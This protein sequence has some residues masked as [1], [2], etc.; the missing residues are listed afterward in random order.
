MADIRELKD[1]AAKQFSKGKF[2]KAARAYEQLCALEPRDVQM[3][4]RLGDALVKN[5]E[6]ETAVKAYQ[7][8]AESYAREGFLPRAI[9]VC[10]L[11]LE[12]DP[13]HESTQEIL[14]NLYARR[15]GRG[16]AGPQAPSGSAP[17]VQAKSP[18]PPALPKHAQSSVAI[19]LDIG[20]LGQPEL[21]EGAAP[22]AK[23]PEPPEGNLLSGARATDDP[24]SLAALQIARIEEDQE[25]E[26]LV[27]M[28]E[29][30][31]RAAL[32]RIPLFSDLSREAFVEIT[33]GCNL[34]RCQAG[35][36]LIEEGAIGASFFVLCS[37]VVKVS[38]R[39]SEGE[40]VLA[41]LKEGAFFG[42]MALLSGSPRVASVVA[43]EDSQCLEI[44]ASL[45]GK[46]LQR[47]PHVGQVLKKFCR[48]RLL[49]NVM[50]TSPLFKPFEKAERK[51]LIE[52]F[53]ARDLESGEKV[54]EE[55]QPSD[56][57]YVVMSGELSVKRRGDGAEVAIAA[58]KEGEVFGEIS[59]LTKRPATA[60]VHAAKPSTVLRLPRQTFDEL[61]C[62]HPQI[63][64]LVSD[65]SDERLQLQQAIDSGAVMAGEEGLM[66]V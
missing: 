4:V 46:L 41:R 19:E 43:E 27:E 35:D 42:E 55:T 11:I 9:A 7:I 8:A 14:A 32:P 54:V 22:P 40:L 64:A 59:L 37:G 17:A 23:A 29:E 47:Y 62:T 66:L 61:V 60:T 16:G 10:K 53:M 57:L 51:V 12:V 24:K 36:T 25:L 1:K 50:A 15:T 34:R 63:L 2:E 13:G 52:K 3:R 6:K 56:G 28:P 65:L 39:S 33:S 44:P 45:L 49:A 38:K 31:G 21:V 30:P 5:G 48:Q 58:L 18:A 26:I 20:D